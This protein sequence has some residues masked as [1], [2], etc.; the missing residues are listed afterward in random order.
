MEDIEILMELTHTLDAFNVSTTKRGQC[1]NVVNDGE[2]FGSWIIIINGG[3]SMIGGK[4][5]TASELS[6]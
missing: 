4:N 6:Q 3:E 1:D 5:I 2:E